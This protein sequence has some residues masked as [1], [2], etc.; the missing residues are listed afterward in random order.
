MTLSNVKNTKN[1][2]NF[3]LRIL[4]K[5]IMD[6]R[7]KSHPATVRLDKLKFCKNLELSECLY[8]VVSD[9]ICGITVHIIKNVLV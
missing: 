1:I 5:F 6:M 2:E 9:V 4:Q 7:L 3:L 8:S